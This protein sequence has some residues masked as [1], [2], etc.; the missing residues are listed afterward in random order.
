MQILLH[1]FFME[2]RQAMAPIGIKTHRYAY[3][4]RTVEGFLQRHPFSG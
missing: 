3:S 4:A 1:P 2:K